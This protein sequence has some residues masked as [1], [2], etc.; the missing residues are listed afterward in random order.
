MQQQSK[1]DQ[2]RADASDPDAWLKSLNLRAEMRRATER[3][4]PRIAQLVQKTNQ[5]NLSL[6][7]RSLDELR[8]LL[9][10]AAVFTIRAADQ[11]GDYGMIGVVIARPNNDNALAIDTFL[12]SCRAL[13]RGIETAALHELLQLARNRGHSEVLAPFV[14]GPRN[15]PIRKFLEQS[16]FD[17][18]SNVFEAAASLNCERPSHIDWTGPSEN[19]AGKAA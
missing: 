14:V 19:V 9:A 6:K 18:Q 17:L 12:L 13:G 15:T 16:G 5:F 11:F 3:D 10:D 2:L 4:L 1:R 8:P 7:R